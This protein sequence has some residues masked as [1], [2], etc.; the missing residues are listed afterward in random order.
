MTR[1]SK[2]L[3]AATAVFFCQVA[4]CQTS[5]A[6]LREYAGNYQWG[7][8]AFVYLQAWAELSG[9]NQLV[10]FDESGEVRALYPAARDSFTAGPG[11]AVPKPVESTI[12]FQ[13]DAAGKIVSLTWARAGAAPRIAKRVEIEQREDVSFSNGDIK[14]AG[15]LIRPATSGKTPAI[16]LVHA[17]GAEDR[18]YLVPLAHFLVRHGVALFGYDKRGVGKSTGD[19]KTASFEDLAGD[20][21]AAF[22]HLKT[23]NDID[24]T[25]IG[26]LGWSQAGWIMP[27]A[28]VRARD[29]SF[30][31]SIS[32]AGV[33]PAETTVDQARNEMT[34]SGMKPEAVDQIVKLMQLQYRYAGTGQGWDEYL[35][36]RQAFVD[37]I[38]RAPPNFPDSRDDSQWT[39]IRKVYLFD[40]APVL[41]QL[42]TPTLAIFGELDNNIVA[43]KN[44][45]A[46]ER[47]L[48]AAGNKDFALR[49]LPKG[50]HLQLEAKTGANSEMPT[51]TRF[52]PSYSATVRDWLRERVRGFDRER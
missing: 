28:A 5:D 32:G 1:G 39:V 47:H 11:A 51:L 14:L 19:W 18:A 48:R 43:E 31:I 13:R 9:D 30:L 52:V 6:A 4:G 45:A 42:R 41:R 34:A 46:W 2:L 10:A 49:I 22:K 25:Q 50:N 3:F 17:S 26:L 20:V 44:R 27:L 35:A 7:P 37:R 29:I 21:V 12:T 33:S 15:T 8:D 36:A 23:R 40:P 24:T 16:I 38:G